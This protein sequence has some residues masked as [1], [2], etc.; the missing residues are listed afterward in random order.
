M[1][2][3]TGDAVYMTAYIYTQPIHYIRVSLSLI[4]YQYIR[5][6]LY[7]ISLQHTRRRETAEQNPRSIVFGSATT[8]S[9]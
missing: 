8:I 9:L 3:E 6:V 2:A 4:L 5:F 7:T 1:V